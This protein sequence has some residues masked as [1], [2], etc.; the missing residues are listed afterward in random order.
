MATSVITAPKFDNPIKI[1][2]ERKDISRNPNG[3]YQLFTVKRSE[4]FSGAKDS[5]VTPSTC[6]EKAVFATSADALTGYV[7][8]YFVREPGSNSKSVYLYSGPAC[9]VYADFEALV[10]ERENRKS[11]PNASVGLVYNNR[12]KK[13]NYPP[14]V[15]LA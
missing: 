3:A 10:F 9:V 7:V 13:G 6:I 1:N 4:D 2:F 14:S 15:A 11:S 5:A 8:I 12:F